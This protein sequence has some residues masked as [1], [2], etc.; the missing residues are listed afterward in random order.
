MDDEED[1]P[2]LEE[3]FPGMEEA[4]MDSQEGL[5]QQLAGASI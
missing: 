5:G 2:E 1:F 4:S 3:A